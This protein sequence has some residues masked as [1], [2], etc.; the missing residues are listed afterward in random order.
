ML[1]R[2]KEGT[3]KVRDESPDVFSV[4]SHNYFPSS[5]S[6]FLSSQIFV[7]VNFLGVFSIKMT[8]L[9]KHTRTMIS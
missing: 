4:S 7:H 3:K 2:G 6:A 1:R 8:S 9:Y 5:Y